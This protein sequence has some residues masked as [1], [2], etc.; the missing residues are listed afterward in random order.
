MSSS[1]PGF[2]LNVPRNPV[3]AVGLPIALGFL[4]GAGTKK[5]INGTWY[6]VRASSLNTTPISP[7]SL[8]KSHLEPPISSRETSTPCFPNY[9]DCVVHRDGLRLLPGDQSLRQSHPTYHQV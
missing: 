1:L 5:V 6:K 3:V 8:T 9:L 2:L 7:K 4:S